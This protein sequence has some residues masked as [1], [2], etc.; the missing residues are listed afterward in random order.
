MGG[1]A[2]NTVTMTK[3]E[4][5][6]VGGHFTATQFY[7]DVEGHPDDPGSARIGR[8]GL[9]HFDAENLAPIRRIPNG[10]TEADSMDRG[11]WCRRDLVVVSLPSRGERFRKR[12]LVVTLGPIIRDRCDVGIARD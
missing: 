5:Y 1:F 11:N 7:S 3:L 8:V 10:T 4:S 12:H 6:T 9:F 2:T